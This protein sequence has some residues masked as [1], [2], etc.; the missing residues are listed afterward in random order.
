[1]PGRVEGDVVETA[2]VFVTRGGA[3]VR[4]DGLP[5]HADR[6]ERAGYRP[7]PPAVADGLEG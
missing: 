2:D 7:G 5:P 6:F 3:L 4:A 1:M